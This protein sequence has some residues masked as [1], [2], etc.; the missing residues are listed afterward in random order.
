MLMFTASCSVEQNINR[1]WAAAKLIYKQQQ[2]WQQ[3]L[4]KLLEGFVCMDKSVFLPCLHHSLLKLVWLTTFEWVPTVIQSETVLMYFF[5]E[6]KNT[7]H[8]T[9]DTVTCVE[10]SSIW[11][12]CLWGKK[13]I[14]RGCLSLQIVWWIVLKW[15]YLHI[16]ISRYETVLWESVQGG[17]KTSPILTDFV[18]KQGQCAELLMENTTTKITCWSIVAGTDSWKCYG[19]KKKKKK[20]WDR[21]WRAM[22]LADNMQIP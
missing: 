16:Y 3:P 7:N 11:T 4:K 20:D 6:M 17:M 22:A 13:N 8:Q 5:S 12:V 2:W 15:Q 19:G 21:F 10:K 18:K 1:Q 9:M 14:C